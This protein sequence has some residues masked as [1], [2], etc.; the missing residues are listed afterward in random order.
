MAEDVFYKKVGNDYV[1]VNYYDSE[2]MDSIPEGAHLIVKRK[3]VDMRRYNVNPAIVPMVAA[4]LYAK[5]TITMALMKASELRIPKNQVP[6]TPPQIEAWNNLAHAFG[7][8]MYSLEWPSYAEVAE[9]GVT[10]MQE[11]AAKLLEHPSVQI[12]YEQF[13]LICKLAKDS[14]NG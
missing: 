11:E 4:G 8:D 14:D 6:L 13:L 2:V 5:D 1:P 7:K 3:G 9:A 10:A 12:A